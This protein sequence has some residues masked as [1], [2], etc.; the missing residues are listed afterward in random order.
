MF[1]FTMSRLSAAYLFAIFWRTLFHRNPIPIHV[2]PFPYFFLP[3]RRLSHPCDQIFLASLLRTFVTR[4]VCCSILF[5]P[6]F[7]MQ[8]VMKWLALF[9]PTTHRPC[10]SSRPPGQTALSSSTELLTTLG[11]FP[12]D[13]TFSQAVFF[14]AAAGS[15]PFPFVIHRL[16]RLLLGPPEA[17][18]LL[19]LLEGWLIPPPPY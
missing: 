8:V 13:P 19:R 14:S 16:C 10:F 4:Q 2:P 17:P 1:S 5:F 3:L 7:M 11:R 18:R 15:C 9:P 12:I 6:P